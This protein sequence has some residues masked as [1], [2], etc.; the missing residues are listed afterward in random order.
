MNEQGPTKMGQKGDTTYLLIGIVASILIAA[1]SWTHFY[2]DQEASIY[3]F[4][5]QLRNDLFGKPDQLSAIATI[6]ID[7]LALQTFGFPFTR[8]RHAVLV[9]ILHKYQARMIGFDIFFYEPSKPLLSPEEI[10]LLEQESFTKNEVIELIK[11]YDQDFLQSAQKK[12][13]VYL[14]QTFEV[15][16]RGA[17][18]AGRN[19]RERTPDKEVA[20]KALASSSI[21]HRVS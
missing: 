19:L 5:F 6:D 15:T 9:D 8:D 16:E 17:D 13:I 21:N 11:D 1:L 12:G 18:F 3:D 7:D 20:L 2:Q 4:R 14:A 10:A